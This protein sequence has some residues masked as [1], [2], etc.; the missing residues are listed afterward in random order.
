M[1]K[2][3]SQYHMSVHCPQEDCCGYVHL[4]P[5]VCEFDSRL[6]IVSFSDLAPDKENTKIY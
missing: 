5:P 1:L 2:V 4:L 6:G 3:M